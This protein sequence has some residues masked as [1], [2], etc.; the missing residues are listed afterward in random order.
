MPYVEVWVEPED[1]DV[2]E[3][4]DDELIDELERRGFKVLDRNESQEIFRLYQSWVTCKDA[5]Y[6]RFEKDLKEFF[7]RNL[8][9]VSV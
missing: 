6:N 2:E 8:N 1:L 4:D 5:N 7:C 3:L 9:K